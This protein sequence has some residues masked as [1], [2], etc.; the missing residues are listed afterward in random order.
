MITIDTVRLAFKATQIHLGSESYRHLTGEEWEAIKAVCDNPDDLYQIVEAELT[1]YPLINEYFGRDIRCRLRQ[2]RPLESPL[3]GVLFPAGSP[4]LEERLVRVK[5]ISGF[6]K[7]FSEYRP[8]GSRECGKETDERT[9]DALAE[10]LALDALLYFGFEDLRKLSGGVDLRMVDFEGRYDGKLYR[11]E[12]TRVRERTF[13]DKLTRSNLEDPNGRQNEE[14]IYRALEGKLEEKKGQFPE[15][16]RDSDN[17]SYNL[18]V[19]KTS[20]YGFWECIDAVGRIALGLLREDRF[21]RYDRLLL[22]P[23]ISFSEGLV[24]AS[25]SC[26][27]IMS[28]GTWRRSGV[29]TGEAQ[30]QDQ[31]IITPF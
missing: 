16:D 27:L 4:N 31:N 15:E 5:D 7:I 17:P 25:K 9:G 8:A 14:V 23:T 26:L 18:L 11:I 13:P 1:K 10:V 24:V 21:D 29:G 3:I 12:V 30:E 2:D 20:D 6:S 19:V 22:I 28:D